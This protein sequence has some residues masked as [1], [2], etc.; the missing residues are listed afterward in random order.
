MNIVF[1]DREALQGHVV[2]PP[3]L[4][5]EET[6]APDG[7]T[8]CPR[9]S[10]PYAPKLGQEPSYPRAVFAPLSRMVCVACWLCAQRFARQS[11]SGGDERDVED[12]LRPRCLDIGMTNRIGGSSVTSVYVK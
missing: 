4:T 3:D 10:G 1:Q 7:N 11:P 12:D 9:T 8:A 6:E 2:Q 5:D